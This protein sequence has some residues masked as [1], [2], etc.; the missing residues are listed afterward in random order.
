MTTDVDKAA[1]RRFFKW[2]RGR[3]N[4]KRIVGITFKFEIDLSNWFW[5]PVTVWK[6][7]GGFHWLCFWTWTNWNYED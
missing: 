2:P 5:R 3:Y 1:E 6:Y 7:A 4:G